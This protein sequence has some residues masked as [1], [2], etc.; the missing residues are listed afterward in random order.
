VTQLREAFRLAVAQPQDLRRLESGEPGVAGDLA[1]SRRA[2]RSLERGRLAR[3]TLIVPQ[4]R[5][6]QR[7]AMLVEEDGAVHLTCH[8]DARD[9]RAARRADLAQRRRRGGP[10]RF[11]LL[12][13]PTGL[14]RKQRVRRARDDCALGVDPDGACPRR[15]E[16][17]A[18]DIDMPGL[19]VHLSRLAIEDVEFRQIKAERARLVL[20]DRL[21]GADASENAR[22]SYGKHD[23]L[24]GTQ[25]FHHLDA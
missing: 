6:A 25:R 20:H 21:F 8:A 1:Q 11:R 15:A 24:L 7:R 5:R 13:G 4:Q 22:L 18:D 9:G 12:L 10:P 3:G 23:V 19:G 14:R 2:D 17:D 16:V